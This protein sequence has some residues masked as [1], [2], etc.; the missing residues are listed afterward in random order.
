MKNKQLQLVR[1]QEI[2]QKHALSQ[3]LAAS[4]SLAHGEQQQLQQLQQYQDDYH[5]MIEAEQGD[6]SAAKSKHYREFCYQLNSVIEA[7]Q[8][9]LEQTKASISE[10]KQQIE[11]QQHKIEVVD[12][13]I[14][15]ETLE[16]LTADNKRFQQESD[17]LVA[18]RYFH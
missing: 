17:A 12:K 15:K 10:Y 7:Q 1:E 4:A 13:L 14:E 3:K 11:K 6:W 18:R 16:L 8:S 2:K 9:K 5:K